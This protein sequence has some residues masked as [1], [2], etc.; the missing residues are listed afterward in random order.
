MPRSVALVLPLALSLLWLGSADADA[1]EKITICHNTSSAKNPVVMIE[2]SVNALD[3]HVLNHGDADPYEVYED[4]DND[5]FGAPGTGTL[6]CETPDGYVEN[7]D[8]S[9]DT[10]PDSED[11]GGGGGDDGIDPPNCIP[12]LEC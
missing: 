12:G 5:G 7:D 1:G 4:S 11:D 9:D 2:I 10:D 6:V 8:D 3:K